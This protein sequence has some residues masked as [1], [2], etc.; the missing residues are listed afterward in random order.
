MD[1][2]RT[3][4][5]R[6]FLLLDLLPFLLLLGSGAVRASSTEASSILVGGQVSLGDPTPARTE[7]VE[8]AVGRYEAAGLEL[9]S[10]DLRFHE[11]D[12]GCH[13]NVGWTDGFEVQLCTRLAMEAG[14][15]RIVLHELA[16]AWCNANLDDA[17]REAFDRF[18]DSSSWNGSTSSWKARGTEQAAEIIGWA[19]GDGTM[20]PLIDGDV[21]PQ[22]LAAAFELLTGR[23]PL[24]GPSVAA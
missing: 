2:R 8:W 21:S 22:G 10:I 7:L 24:H 13:G 5:P 17:D 20:L 11:T 14:P 16:H 15:Q 1:I 3:S 12:A 6:H 23:A 4:H 19:L 18:R 9:P